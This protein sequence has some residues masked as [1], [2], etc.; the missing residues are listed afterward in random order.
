MLS[1]SI[2]ALKKQDFMTES[3]T[4][5]PIISLRY[6]VLVRERPFYPEP[7]PE[8]QKPNPNRALDPDS[9]ENSDGNPDGKLDG[10][11]DGKPDGKR[12]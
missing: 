2:Q 4:P 8:L 6:P 3:L 1:N 7:E 10:K 9:D 12:G 11:L 5:V